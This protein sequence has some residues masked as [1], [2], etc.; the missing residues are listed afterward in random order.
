MTMPP[1]EILNQASELASEQHLPPWRSLMLVLVRLLESIDLPRDVQPAFAAARQY[2]SSPGDEP[3]LILDAKI[4]CWDYL[5][6]FPPGQDLAVREGRR[7]RALLCV[8]ELDGD[9][10]SASVTAEWFAEMTVGDR[11]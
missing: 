7:V 3:A 1:S 4:L 9:E 2:W 10:E 6:Q 11:Q 8:L 5:Q